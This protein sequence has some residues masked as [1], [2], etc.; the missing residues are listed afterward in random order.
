MKNLKQIVGPSHQL[1]AAM[2]LFAGGL[3]VG[4]LTHGLAGLITGAVQISVGAWIVFGMT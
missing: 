1:K 3:V 2:M 4:G